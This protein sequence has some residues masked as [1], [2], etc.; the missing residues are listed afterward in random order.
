ME[1]KIKLVIFKIAQ[2]GFALLLSN[3]ERIVQIVEI[4]R[5]PKMPEHV[6]GIINLHGEIIPV[7]NL[8]FLFNLPK[9]EIELSDQLIIAN[10]STRKIA[11]LVD[12]TQDVVEFS[13]DKIIKSDKIMLGIQY[14]KGVIKLDGGMVFFND[15][16][17][18]LKPEELELLETSLK[19]NT[20]E[21]IKKV[22]TS[23][24][25]LNV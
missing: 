6:S 24:S 23:K 1:I 17:K 10:T 9:K 3:I 18:F 2:Q 25:K 5:L 11:L 19:D 20:K 21:K 22:Q 13:E 4:K 15:L 14:I 16:D 8:R 7:I 12:S